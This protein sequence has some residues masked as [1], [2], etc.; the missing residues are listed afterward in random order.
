MVFDCDE[1]EKRIHVFKKRKFDTIGSHF[2]FRMSNIDEII[3]E[4]DQSHTKSRLRECIQ[5]LGETNKA[6][7]RKIEELEEENRDL[8]ELGQIS[9][10]IIELLEHK[11]K[12]FS[13]PV[14]VKE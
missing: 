9:K 1:N 6:Q 11:I 3:D 14:I 7:K 5:T 13:A 12:R 8:S 2:C 10:K 4:S